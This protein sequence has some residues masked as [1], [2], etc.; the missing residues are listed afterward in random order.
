MAKGEVHVSRFLM[1]RLWP[2][3][4]ARESR[5]E[6]AVL[7]HLCILVWAAFFI[8]EVRQ[9]D[10]FFSTLIN[11]VS[12]YIL[13]TGGGPL[14][15]RLATYTF[16][17]GC[18]LGLMTSIIALL[19]LKQFALTRLRPVELV[20]A[21]VLGAVSQG[22]V[23]AYFFDALELGPRLFG[24]VSV[25]TSVLIACTVLEPLSPLLP[26][27]F[28]NIPIALLVLALLGLHAYN[29]PAFMFS[30]WGMVV[31]F[32]QMI[33]LVLLF[34]GTPIVILVGIWAARPFVLYI[35]FMFV[36]E[37]TQYPARLLVHLSVIGAG[38]VSGLVMRSIRTHREAANI[39]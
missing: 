28:R 29:M 37:A 36:E 19:L 3:P 33:V 7:V 39:S 25:I 9:S 10:L 11:V 13:G 14:W 27:S 5:I 22:L 8:W 38:V 24:P 1:Q 20:G 31:I 26:R 30:W 4:G 2:A 18:L 35:V 23:F 17:H 21:Y 34:A 15:F 6:I 16:V 32:S 12:P